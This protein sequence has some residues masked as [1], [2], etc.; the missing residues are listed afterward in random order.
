MGYL[1][2][3]DLSKQRADDI[4]TAA[5]VSEQV[6]NGVRLNVNKSRVYSRTQ[7]ATG[8]IAI[9]GTVVGGLPGRA[10]IACFVATALEDVVHSL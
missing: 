4:G 5:S 10:E 6:D 8:G 3:V 1:D 9:L 2:E 7:I